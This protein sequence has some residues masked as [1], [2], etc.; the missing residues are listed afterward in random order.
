MKKRILGIAL[1]LVMV[2]TLAACGSDNNTQ[3]DD[4]NTD[5]LNNT[6]LPTDSTPSVTNPVQ[7]HIEAIPFIY[8]WVEPFSEGLAWVKS[9][10][11]WGVIDKDGN[12]VIRCILDFEWVYP[13]SN[14]LAAVG[15]TGFMGFVD[16]TGQSLFQKGWRLLATMMGG[17]ILTQRAM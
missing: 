13:F 10:G 12:E 2:L 11:R 3:S 17:A 8:D 16:T 1:A 4:D 14:G 9:G 7:G 5:R 15:S 6:S